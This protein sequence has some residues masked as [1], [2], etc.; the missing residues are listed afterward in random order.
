M[1]IPFNYHW[2]YHD[3]FEEEMKDTSYS[4]KHMQPVSIP[5]TCVITPYHYFDESIYQMVSGYRKVFYAPMKWKDSMIFL[6][7]DGVLHIAHVYLNGHLIGTHHCGYTSFTVDCTQHLLYDSDNILAISVDSRESNNIPP[8]GN[9]IDYMTYGGIYREV[10]LEVKPTIFLEDVFVQTTNVLYEEKLL[11]LEISTNELPKNLSLSYSLASYGDEELDYQLLGSTSLTDK[12]TTIT[13]TIREVALWSIED[14]NLYWIRVELIDKNLV[15]DTKEIR[16]G[17]REAIFKSNGFYLNGTPTKII[18]LN[19]HQSYPYVGYAM[20]K[21]VQQLDADILKNELSLN[22]VRTSHY[23]Q[24]QHFI[25]RCDEL[26]LLVFTEIVGW[27]HIGDHEWKEITLKTTKEMILQYR[28]HPSIII[29]GVRINESQDDDIFYR[30]TNRIAHELDP[31]RATGGVRFITKSNLLEDVYTF[32]DFSHTGNNAGTQPKDKVT[33]N[34]SKP[35]LV[36]E[37]NGHMFPTK[38]FDSESHR[39]EHALRHSNVLQGIYKDEDITGGFGWCMF[40]YNTHKDFGSG[41]RICYHGVMTMFRNPK[42][43]A[44]VYASQCEHTPVLAISS[45][46][47]IGEHPGGNLSCVYAFTNADSVRLYKNNEFVKEFF[48]NQEQFS[49]LPHPPILINDFIGE[50]MRAEGYSNANETRIKEVLQAISKYGQN[51]LPLSYKIK[52]GI[53]MLQEKLTMEDGIRLY[54]KYIGNWGDKTTT[55]RFD[56]IKDRQVIRSVEKQSMT[57]FS[58]QVNS[59][60]YELTEEETYDVATLRMQV[61]D[62]FHEVL[63]YYHGVLSILVDGN[64]E[65]IGPSHINMQAGYC[66]T[67]IRS[68]G[69]SGTGTVT[70]HAEGTTPVTISYTITK[71]TT[72]QITNTKK[73]L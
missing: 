38:A 31:T 8:F 59:D 11:S 29:W 69:K 15:I 42:L 14:P 26:G 60:T 18:G 6:R 57:Q 62:E 12:T 68:V 37:Y 52:M 23:P 10:T 21:R 9:V 28:N 50:L 71:V 36:T 3:T 70:L 2:F 43:A 67:Y 55:Y 33:S 17:F 16:F 47:N 24:S 49:A 13:H 40:D 7:F 41:D 30:E 35:Y 5:H 63:P 25:D 20:P 19:R 51:H 72:S 46:M 66:G 54:S 56:G 45:T 1:I 53:A 44:S 27:Q 4:T 22:A 32:N 73:G 48:P 39:L 34:C 58:L 61:V 65:L 64:I